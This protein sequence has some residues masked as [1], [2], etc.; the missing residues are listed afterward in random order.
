MTRPRHINPTVATAPYNFVSL[1]ERVYTVDSGVPVGEERKN[2]WEMHDRYV[3]GTRSGWIDLEIRTL[4]P[5][6]I[7]GAVRRQGGAWDTREARFRPEPFRDPDGRPLIPGSSLRGMTRTLVE[8]LS[9]AKISPVNGDKPFFRTVGPDSLGRAY[10][11]RIAPGGA[12]PGGGFLKKDG[13]R[14]LIVP[15]PEILRV[16]RDLLKELPG[17]AGIPDHPRPDYS[18][19][20]AGQHKPCRFRRG[21]GRHA[22]KIAQITL[23]N[24]HPD[25]ESGTLVLT[26]SAPNKKF[27]FVFV[28]KNP[29]AAITIPENIWR[30]FHDDDQLTRWQETA[31]PADRP[32]RGCRP[33]NGFLR[34]GE[35]VFYRL[36]EKRK[37]AENPSGLVFFGRA[38]M[39]RLPYDLGPLDLVPGNTGAAGLD[40]AEALFGTI[41]GGQAIKGRVFFEDAV[42]SGENPAQPGA[43]DAIVPRILSAPK[44][45]CFQHYLVQDG[46]GR[47]DRLLTYLDRDRGKTAIR[48]HKLYWHRWAEAQGIEQVKEPQDHD[49]LKRGLERAGSDADTQ[50]TIIRP[51]DDVTFAGRVRFENLADIELG[52]LLCALELPEGCAHKLGMGKPLGL[53]SVRIR[54]VL[55]LVDREK[56]YND[57]W[58]DDGTSDAGNG[59]KGGEACREAFSGAMLDHARG[60]GETLIDG[61]DGLR[62]I[63]RLE[64]LYL[65]LAWETRLPPGKTENMD[66]GMF[67][68]R[69]VLPTPHGA[70]GKTEPARATGATRAHQAVAPAA[71]APA[72]AVVPTAPPLETPPG[73]KPIN[74]GQTREGT[75]HRTPAD[76]WVARFAGD[77]RD[78]VITGDI[79]GDTPDSARAEFY[80]M[81]QSKKTGIRARLEK[82]L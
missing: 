79:P 20:W 80:I 6:F 75:L 25:W 65:M 35:P 2:P 19:P 8:I 74:Q 67:R 17:L 60:S 61:Q 73:F 53:G 56:R 41:A 47:R 36:D 81:Q 1:P 34:E 16:H 23:E 76:G 7:R 77:G 40:L 10:R 9:F 14:W 27:D 38:G 46:T 12:K 59:A 51:V 32:T 57:C 22:W 58:D 45:T 48:G 24:N 54:P 29:K 50:H 72:A 44:P 5:L 3:P 26:G 37:C 39:F 49:R 31:F 4:T 33:A 43:D 70:A 62:A 66:V 18:P 13:E 82:I 52:A 15:A 30:R 71:T 78:A 68:H 55:H 28:G 21:A 63:A 42:A 64:A 11:E 69:P